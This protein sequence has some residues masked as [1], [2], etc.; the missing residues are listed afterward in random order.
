[1]AFASVKYSQRRLSRTSGEESFRRGRESFAKRVLIP[2]GTIIVGLAGGLFIGGL[3]AAGLLGSVTFVPAFAIGVG[4][5][6]LLGA[7]WDLFHGLQD[8]YRGAADLISSSS[9]SLAGSATPEDKFGPAGYDGEGTPQGGEY[10]F[11]GA[12]PG[13]PVP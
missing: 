8:L 10:R 4:L 11:V 6:A 9:G 13:Q 5:G 12:G 1:M 2:K 3:A 7:A